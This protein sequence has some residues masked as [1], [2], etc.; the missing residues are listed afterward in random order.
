MVRAS[1][2]TSVAKFLP[3]KV[4][5]KGTSNTFVR[6]R[7]EGRGNAVTV[8]KHFNILVIYDGICALTQVKYKIRIYFKFVNSFTALLLQSRAMKNT[9]LSLLSIDNMTHYLDICLS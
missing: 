4:T 2:V 7:Q 5:W 3:M 8:S 1:L 9:Q 6:I